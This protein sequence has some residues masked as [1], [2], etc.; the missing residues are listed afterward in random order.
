[1]NRIALLRLSCLLF[2]SSVGC[3]PEKRVIWSHDGKTAAIST[4][5]GLR[6]AAADGQLLGARLDCTAARAAWFPDNRRLAIAYARE[7]KGWEQI[8]PIYSPQKIQDIAKAAQAAKERVLAYDGDWSRFKLDPDGGHSPGMNAAILFYLRDRLP[9]G[10]PE[11]LGDKWADFREA[12]A[13]IWSLQLFDVDADQL[14]PGKLLRQSLDE[15]WMPAVSPRGEAIAY[16]AKGGE[17]QG[18]AVGL[19]VISVRGGEPRLIHPNVAM[20]YDWSA[21]G[22]SLVYLCGPTDG[23]TDSAVTLGSVSTIEVAAE[24]GSL[25]ETFNKQEDHVGVLFSQLFNVRY[26]RDGRLMF[27]SVEFT[28]P[29]TNRDMPQRWTLFVLDP[30]TPASVLRVLPRDFS[31]PMEMTSALF[32]LSPDETRVL[33]PGSKGRLYLYDFA[34]GQTHAI[35][36]EDVNERTQTV[37]AWRNNDEFTFVRPVKS[38]DGKDGGQLTQWKAGATRP[39]DNDWPEEAREG[40]LA[41]Q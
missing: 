11:K 36:T 21:D 12:N 37:P 5:K 33:I 14:T 6:L 2:V 8:A 3:I 13:T 26:L 30:R 15:M 24:N 1:M 27:S 28:L 17:A 32:Q 9:D 20:G 40:W 10:L 19:Y 23:R 18:D 29:A 7:V 39:L 34:T 38:A 35:Q 25:L 4:H 31:E 22:R 16:L 41:P